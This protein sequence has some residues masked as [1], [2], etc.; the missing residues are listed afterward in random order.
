M[1]R[2]SLARHVG[3]ASARGLTETAVYAAIWISGSYAPSSPNGT[4]LWQRDGGWW[5][6][7]E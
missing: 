6:F 7:D 5:V 4:R 3:V 1:F 2:D